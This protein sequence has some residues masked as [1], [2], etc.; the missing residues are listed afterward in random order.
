[1]STSKEII[2]AC[3]VNYANDIADDMHR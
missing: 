2:S 3:H 1:L